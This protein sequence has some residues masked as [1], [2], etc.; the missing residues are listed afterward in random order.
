M[1]YGDKVKKI[2][3][4]LSLLLLCGC[5]SQVR[6]EEDMK[7][8]I[9]VEN[10]SYGE[11]IT[12][13]WDEAYPEHKEAVTYKVIEE[14]E[15]IVSSINQTQIPYDVF[16]IKDEDVATVFDQILEIPIQFAKGF[17]IEPNSAFYSVINDVKNVYYPLM[18][19]G[20]LYAV[21][22]TKAA[23]ENIDLSV[24]ENFETMFSYLDKK[25][26]YYYED[27]LFDLPLL[28]S[29]VDYLPNEKS[30]LV[31]FESE[32]FKTSLSNYKE[33][34]RTLTL[35][36]DP[37]SFDNWFIN[38]NYLSGLIGPWMQAN[39]SEEINGIELHYQKLPKINDLQLKSLAV[40]QGYVINS[41]T[42]YPNAALKLLELMHSQAGMQVLVET[43]YQVPLI[44]EKDIELFTMDKRHQSEKVLAMNG[45]M[46][47][48]LLALYQNTK[49]GAIEILKDPLIRT[50]IIKY[51][52]DSATL[53]E[54]ITECTLRN[55]VWLLEQSKNIVK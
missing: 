9:A 28:S 33:I 7:L 47:K 5:S 29:D 39:Q 35:Q 54:T 36:S 13:L 44:L 42:A 38:Q 15:V 11:A 12:A 34:M 27:E 4:I 41:K 10:E 43:S 50:S 45:A 25:P 1:V 32:A 51:L 24:F 48:N 21:N 6:I 20:M 55:D 19:D 2:K 37:S 16:L 46:Q 26:F 30:H 40:S 17:E 49:I 22:K 53:E 31:D 8:H 52:L 23:S 14:N 3:L 18:A